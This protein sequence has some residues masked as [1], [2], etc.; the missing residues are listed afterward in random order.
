M[1]IRGGE[2]QENEECK[3]NV[4]WCGAA[5]DITV[6]PLTSIAVLERK[7]ARGLCPEVSFFFSV[8]FS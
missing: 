5:G 2:K 7:K 6:V 1:H 8:T 4:S 3:T